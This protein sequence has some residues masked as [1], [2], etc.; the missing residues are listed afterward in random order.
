MDST[1]VR[2]LSRDGAPNEVLLV[3]RPSGHLAVLKRVSPELRDRE[4]V[5]LRLNQERRLLARLGGRHGLVGL[6]DDAT[7][8][9]SLLVRYLSGGSLRECIDRHAP[10]LLPPDLVARVAIELSAAVRH[11]HDHAVIH[12]DV[13]PTNIM[14]DSSGRTWLIDLSVAAVGRPA[15]ALPDGWEEGRIG[16]IPYAAPETILHAEAPV[17]AS[18][19]IYSL[20][21]V[22]WE[23]VTRS[24]PFERG[25]AESP[26][27]FARRVTS[28]S[29]TVPTD[30][31]NR[32]G[33]RFA[34]LVS[35]MVDASAAMRPE[36][37]AVVERELRSALGTAR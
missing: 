36:S 15:K 29:R 28:A 34:D 9:P 21:V 13:N 31:A 11:L 23:M 20:G 22:F 24:R 5:A 6:D 3:R 14:F 10:G 2:V 17:L 1:V 12:R 30:V 16:T 33:S 32:M 37:M 26:D 35:R 8:P 18:V 19:D 4:D 7:E 25:A 27:R